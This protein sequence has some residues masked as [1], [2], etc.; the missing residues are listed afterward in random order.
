MKKSRPTVFRNESWL[1]R[2]RDEVFAFFADARNLEAIT[3]PWLRF[4]VVTP[5]PIT[6]QVGLKIDYRLRVR[7]LPMRWQSEIT[8]WNPPMRFVDEQRRGPYRL[9]RH[10]HRFEDWGGGTLCIDVVHYIAPGG[11][12]RKWIDRLWVGPDIARIFEFRRRAMNERFGLQATGSLIS[13]MDPPS[14]AA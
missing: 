11:L 3:P 8:L 10:E 7:G 9:W 5:G 6:M 1:P 4:R 2:P 12:L 13:K 14:G